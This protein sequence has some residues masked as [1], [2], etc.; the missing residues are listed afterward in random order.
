M[1]I[2]KILNKV[3]GKTY[4]GQT[5]LKLSKRIAQHIYENKT[6]IQKAINKYG[7]E[8]FTISIIDY[9]NS[10]EILNEKEIY[11]IKT[12]N[13]LVPFGYNLTEGGK[14][15]AHIQ[16]KIVSEETRKKLSKAN[17]GK[18]RTE[19]QNK[20]SSEAHKGK[21][22]PEEIRKKLSEAGKGHIVSKETKKKISEAN[23]GKKRSEKTKNV[24]SELKIG[25][26]QN[27]EHIAARTPLIKEAWRKRKQDEQKMLE[28]SNKISVSQRN[29]EPISEETRKLMSKS[30]K[31][32]FS[33]TPVSEETRRKLS[34]ARKGKKVVKKEGEEKPYDRSG[35]AHDFS[36]GMRATHIIY[37]TD[38]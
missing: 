23:V 14:G 25:K 22:I 16:T 34:E 13:S 30:Q 38:I 32:R 20:R 17:M 27:S 1:I 21:V 31:K 3:N 24:M 18:K 5:T 2:Y 35:K 4:I 7:I 8:S 11:W 36:R 19:E 9:A 28:F 37:L 12:L 29:R 10:H 6:P 26:K 33:E 15:H